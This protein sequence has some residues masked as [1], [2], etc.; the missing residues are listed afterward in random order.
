MFLAELLVADADL[1]T[2]KPPTVG[3]T[4]NSDTLEQ[5]NA[6]RGAIIAGDLEVALKLVNELT[7]NLLSSSPKLHFKLLRQQLVELIRNR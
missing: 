6:I 2:P 3:G 1:P 7:P 4:K 5:R